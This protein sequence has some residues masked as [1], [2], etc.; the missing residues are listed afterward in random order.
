MPSIPGIGSVLPAL[1]EAPPALRACLFSLSGVAFAVDVR[2]AREVAVF[3]E[4][5]TVPRASRH[6]IGVAN[7]R[8]AIVPIVEIRGS[9]GL[10]EVETPAARGLRTLVVCD[11]HL[12]AAAVVD[13]VLGLEPFDTILPPDSPAAAR[14][15][16]RRQLF[17][18]WLS[19]AGEIVPVLDVPR[20]LSGLH[21][22]VGPTETSERPS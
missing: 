3:D 12:V 10:P 7:L 9:L 14:V 13:S 2:S 19:W 20:L 16:A 4:I 21:A 11:G 18:G 17:S 1:P 22:T 15:R 8:G 5:T 6:L